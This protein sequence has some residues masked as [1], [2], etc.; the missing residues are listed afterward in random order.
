MGGGPP[1]APCSTDAQGL[2]RG[3]PDT[4]RPVLSGLRGVPGRFSSLIS[5]PTA[6]GLSGPSRLQRLGRRA[7]PSDQPGRKPG[8][9]EGDQSAGLHTV[10]WGLKA[11]PEQGLPEVRG[12]GPPPPLGGA[13][14]ERSTRSWPGKQTARPRLKLPAGPGQGTPTVI[15]PPRWLREHICCD[16]A[17]LS[18]LK[19]ATAWRTLGGDFPHDCGDKG[20]A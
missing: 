6:H 20:T 7:S 5:N 8:A 14:S 11:E 3:A 13:C 1:H 4:S 9:G 10:L 12:E 16:T 17:E 15:L 18:H 19:V 2:R